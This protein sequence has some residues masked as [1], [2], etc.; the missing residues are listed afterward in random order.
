VSMASLDHARSL[1]F[2]PGLACVL[3][4]SAWVL[5]SAGASGEE[6]RSIS[7]SA[8]L[9]SQ[10][11][12]YEHGEG[13]VKDQRKAALLYCE[14]ARDGDPDGAFALGW[15]YANGRGVARSDAMAGF[16]FS[17]A[18]A[19]GHA[20]AREMQSRLGS[21]AVAMPD[22]MKTVEADAP[23]MPIDNTADPFADLPLNKKKIASSHGSRSPLSPSNRISGPRRNPP[24]T[25]GA[26]CSL[27]QRPRPGSRSAIA[28]TSR[29]TY[30][31]DSRTCAGSWLITREK[32][33]W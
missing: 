8:E 33:R 21:D 11:V 10:A 27:F 12:A 31:G 4:V 32:S 3:A 22:C 18:A 1:V 19:A 5:P 29:I 26:S 2:G 24:K 17:I 30:V 20:Q 28:S 14:A 13:V 6:R 9:V 16:L 23:P 15:M 25:R 7:A